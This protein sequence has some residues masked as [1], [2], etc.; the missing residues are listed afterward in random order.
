MQYLKSVTVE[1]SRVMGVLGSLYLSVTLLAEDP[2]SEWGA[3][4]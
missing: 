2:D 4:W 3:E 1:N